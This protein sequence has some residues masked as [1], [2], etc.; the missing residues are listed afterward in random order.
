M[1]VVVKAALAFALVAS[2]LAL[3]ACGG[4][5]GESSA[6]TSAGGAPATTGGGG[7]AVDGAEVFATAGCANCHTL[8]AA[9]AN[10]DVGPNLDELQPSKERVVKQVTNGGGVMP[11]F[12]DQLSEAQIDAVAEY[13]SSSTGGGSSSSS[14]YR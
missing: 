4:D 14:R 1:N 2:V 7:G 8:E 9:G 10:G 3:G 5:E 12:K 6:T 11:S 13:V